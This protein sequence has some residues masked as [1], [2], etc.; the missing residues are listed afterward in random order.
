MAAGSRTKMIGEK[1]MF[2]PEVMISCSVTKHYPSAYIL[3]SEILAKENSRSKSPFRKERALHLD[4]VETK[5]SH[6]QGRSQR[7]SVDFCIG[8]SRGK[9]RMIRLVEAK[10]DVANLK[11]SDEATDI[12]AKVKHSN[13]MLVGEG[14]PVESGAVVLINNSPVVQ[15]QK[16]W[17]SQKLFAK[18]HH[19]SVLT[20]NEFYD[21]YFKKS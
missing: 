9:A 15:Q 4:M 7:P 2:A 6:I 3:I 10:F 1:W 8:I 12:I 14:V 11:K 19:Y 13:E 20:V 17:L 16:R 18:G 21:D 5:T